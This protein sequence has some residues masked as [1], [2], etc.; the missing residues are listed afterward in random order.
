LWSFGDS[1]DSTQQATIMI[2]TTAWV[3]DVSVAAKWYLRDEDLLGQADTVLTEFSAGTL[4]LTAPAFFFDEAGNIL[5]SAVLRRRTT[6]PRAREDYA[7]LLGLGI[8]IVE[9]DSDRRRETLDLALEH[10]IAYYDAL[11]LQLA[12]ELAVPLL[13]ADEPLFKRVVSTFPSVVF[14]GDL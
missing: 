3:L 9:A 4:A 14:L 10:Q 13:T 8:L 12:H 5:R 6:E 11:Y 2:A 7:S 1:H